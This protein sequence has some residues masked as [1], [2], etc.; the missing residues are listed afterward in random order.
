[1]QSEVSQGSR[2]TIELPMENRRDAKAQR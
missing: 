1:V 2:F